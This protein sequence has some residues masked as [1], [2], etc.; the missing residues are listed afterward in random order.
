MRTLP[1]ALFLAGTLVLA[2]SIAA[3]TPGEDAKAR[4]DALNAAKREALDRFHDNRTAAIENH[5]LAINKTRASFI[6]NKTRVIESCKANRTIAYGQANPDPKCIQ[7]G[8]R[9]LAAKARAEHKA[10]RDAFHA[11]MDA[12][13]ENARDWFDA[14]RAMILAKYPRPSGR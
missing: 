12:A 9:P 1:L 3:A 2:A 11:R 4:R 10:A 13:K 8:L 5:T 7:D 6:E 14:Q